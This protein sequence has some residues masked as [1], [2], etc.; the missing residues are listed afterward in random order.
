MRDAA[1]G[2]CVR[3][4]TAGEDR[5]QSGES[6]TAVDGARR[7]IQIRGPSLENR[8][9]L[10]LLAAFF[11]V[12]LLSTV[13]LDVFVRSAWERSLAGEIKTELTQK[14]QLFALLYERSQLPLS[15][16]VQQVSKQSAARATII[17]ADGKVLADS[18]AV[19]EKMEN[20]AGRPEFKAALAGTPG[21][22]MRTSKTVGVDF[23]YIAV[24]AKGGAVRLAYPL[25]IIKQST[26]EIRKKIV[27]DSIF[28]FFLGVLLAAA[29]VGRG[30][31]RGE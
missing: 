2:G 15:E 11:I 7:R 29:L 22:D 21:S 16:L 18:E 26:A 27:S 23:L 5:A 28:A 3:S 25:A 13:T 19:P 6:A 14:T 30:A 20:H 17:Q 4:Q 24:P 12:I 31:P 8:L 9:F 10:R 1:L